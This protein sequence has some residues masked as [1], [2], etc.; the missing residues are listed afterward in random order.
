[1]SKQ[2]TWCKRLCCE[3]AADVCTWYISITGRN[4]CSLPVLPF[5]R[6]YAV[7]DKKLAL[8]GGVMVKDV[9]EVTLNSGEDRVF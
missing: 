9:R 8:C 2:I 5:S 1:M 4:P 6:K 7:V 3:Y